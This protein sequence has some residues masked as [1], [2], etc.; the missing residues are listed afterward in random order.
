MLPHTSHKDLFL[1]IEESL[2]SNPDV[3]IVKFPDKPYSQETLLAAKYNKCPSFNFIVVPAQGLYD[4]DSLNTFMHSLLPQGFHTFTSFNLPE[5]SSIPDYIWNAEVKDGYLK[6]GGM[7]FNDNLAL[8]NIHKLKTVNSYVI[9][10]VLAN[11]K[12]F[13]P[14]VP[15]SECEE[16]LYKATT[17]ITVLPSIE[18]FNFAQP[19]GYKFSAPMMQASL[20]T[21]EDFRKGGKARDSRIFWKRLGHN[22]KKILYEDLLLG[23]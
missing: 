19:L 15:Q 17:R 3:K 8:Q 12:I 16:H 6:F 10:D 1:I 13:Q 18:Y 22:T 23:R 20:G 11:A 4:A 7:S 9:S 21:M 2:K 14:S 5:G